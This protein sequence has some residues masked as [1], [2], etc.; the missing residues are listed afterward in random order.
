MSPI[1][2]LTTFLLLAACSLQAATTQINVLSFGARAATSLST[3]FDNTAAFNAA[4]ASSASGNEIIVPEGYFYLASGWH[5]TNSNR[6]VIAAPGA[7]IWCDRATEL[8]SVVTFGRTDGSG[9]VIT[10]VGWEGGVVLQTHQTADEN[11]IAFTYARNAWVERATVTAPGQ[12]GI[13]AQENVS[14]LRV[15]NNYLISC[16]SGIS[17]ETGCTNVTVQANT[18]RTTELNGIDITTGTTPCVNVNVMDNIIDGAGRHGIQTYLANNLTISGNTITD[19][20]FHGILSSSSIGA[21][22]INNTVRNAAGHGIYLYNVATDADI[23][24]NQVF[25]ASRSLQYAY[26]GI[27]S[28]LCPMRLHY[29]L[30]TVSGTN[31]AFAIYTGD[32]AAGLPVGFGNKLTVNNPTNWAYGGWVPSWSVD[33]INGVEQ[34]TGAFAFNGTNTI[35]IY[36]G[37]T[38]TVRVY[39]NRNVIGPTTNVFGTLN[40]YGTFYTGLLLTN[41]GGWMLGHKIDSG[42]GHLWTTGTDATFDTNT[43]ATFTATDSGTFTFYTNTVTTLRLRSSDGSFLGRTYTV[44][45][46]LFTADNLGNLSAV[47]GVFS[48]IFTTGNADVGGDLNVA[49]TITTPAFITDTLDTGTLTILTNLIWGMTNAAPANT[50]AVLWVP[51]TYGGNS[52]VMPLM[53]LP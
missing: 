52:Y 10:N 46:G 17:I 29:A 15:L 7:I 13:T 3:A 50:N 37:P 22:I 39:N 32:A 25:N 44:P 16:E 27:R 30:N 4:A 47:A 53:A 21:N 23:T 2:L 33:T 49:G 8:G 28:E 48:T 31:H 42:N 51:V 12:K 26:D 38:G 5:I 11:G 45:S 18:I 41:S 35:T 40:V 34:R 43:V 6:R 1:K 19:A 24:A 14:D 9:V 36:P 20:L